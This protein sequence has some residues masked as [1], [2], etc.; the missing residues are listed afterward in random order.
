MTEVFFFFI[1]KEQ[2]QEI[3]E[4]FDLF[5]TEKSGTIDYHELKVVMRALGFDVRKNEVLQLMREYDRD[6]TGRVEYPDFVEISNSL[7]KFSLPIK[8]FLNGFNR[9]YLKKQKPCFFLQCLYLFKVI[10]NGT[11]GKTKQN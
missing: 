11:L 8:G 7:Y 2:K 1:Q 3:K 5:D 4:A 6:E 9:F 10:R